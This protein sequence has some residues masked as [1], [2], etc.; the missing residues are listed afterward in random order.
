MSPLSP[1]RDP[2]HVPAEVLAAG[3]DAVR[4]APRDGGTVTM[5]VTRP[6]VDERVLHERAALDLA[7]GLVGDTWAERG[8]SRTPDGSANPEA[9]VTVMN[10]RAAL[11]MAGTSDRVPLAG[12]QVYLDLDLSVD[13]L[14]TGTVL[15][16][17]DAALEVTAAPH[18][19]CA[20]FSARFG[21]DALRLTA[22]PDGRQLRLRG[23]N[24]RVVRAGTVG[25]GDAVT[26]RRPET[27]S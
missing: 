13:N 18:T 12:D 23:I 27:P 24:T 6:G 22:T 15:E 19:G 7:H 26:V 14:P 16:F 8:S 10:S 9:Q 2:A 11:L 20:K 25:V 1:D 3:L 4:A 5:L 17:A 21:V